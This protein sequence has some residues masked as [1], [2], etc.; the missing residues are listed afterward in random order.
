MLRAIRSEQA[1]R[2]QTSNL[3]F[4]AIGGSSHFHKLCVGGEILLERYLSHLNQAVA[5]PI[6]K[7]LPEPHVSDV[8]AP[9][10]DILGEQRGG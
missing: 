2:D 3:R 9:A 10:N 4:Q 5:L 8:H 7:L 1:S 6:A